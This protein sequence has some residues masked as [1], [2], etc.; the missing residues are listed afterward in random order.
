MLASY[1]QLVNKRWMDR[2]RQTPMMAAAEAGQEEVVQLLEERGGLVGMQDEEGGTAV[3]L[4]AAKGHVEVRVRAGREV[5]YP[6]SWR[7]GH[8][9][10]EST[11]SSCMW[12]RW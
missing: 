10:S 5:L 12:F 4:A 9:H 2:K 1:P 11:H 3:M 8:M 6:Q 7:K